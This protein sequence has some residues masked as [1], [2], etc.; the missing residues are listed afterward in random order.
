VTLKT[1]A[2][3]LKI[4]RCYQRNKIQFYNIEKFHNITVLVYFSD[5]YGFGEHKKH[6]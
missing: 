5:E 6:E 2:M 4:Q 1:R 3:M